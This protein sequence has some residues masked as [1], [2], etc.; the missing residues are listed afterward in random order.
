MRNTSLRVA[1]L[2][3]G[4]LDA[5]LFRIEE[6]RALIR[7]KIIDKVRERR[8]TTRYIMKLRPDIVN[9]YALKRDGFRALDAELG[10]GNVILNQWENQLVILGDRAKITIAPDA[11]FAFQ[12]RHNLLAEHRLKGDICPACFGLTSVPLSYLVVMPGVGLASSDT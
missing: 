11:V 3:I 1:F 5:E 4:A 7:G 6:K 9:A 12:Q 10:H 8:A 2:C